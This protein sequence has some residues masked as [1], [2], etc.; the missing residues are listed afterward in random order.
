MAGEVMSG[1][2]GHENIDVRMKALKEALVLTNHP[3][4]SLVSFLTYDSIRPK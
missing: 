2:S 4:R 3:C 1:A